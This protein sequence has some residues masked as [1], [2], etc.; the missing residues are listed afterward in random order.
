M[1]TKELIHEK[2]ELLDEDQARLILAYIEP[3]LR[4]I[5]RE[6]EGSTPGMPPLIA[7]AAAETSDSFDGF[8]GIFG[9]SEPSDIANHK[10]EYIADAIE[11]HWK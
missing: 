11:L 4:A 7:T 5:E 10:D 9:Y 2:V 8:I 6:S 1:T 3:K